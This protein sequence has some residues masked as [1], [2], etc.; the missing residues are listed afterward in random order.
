MNQVQKVENEDE[1]LLF[2]VNS[3]LQDKYLSKHL[4][5]DLGSLGQF[6]KVNE[7]YEPKRVSKVK[8]QTKQQKSAEELAEDQKRLQTI[9]QNPIK[10]LANDV[11]ETNKKDAAN[12]MV[13]ELIGKA[14]G[15]NNIGNLKQTM[16]NELNFDMTQT[17]RLNIIAKSNFYF[18]VFRSYSLVDPQYKQEIEQ[19]LL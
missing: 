10:V 13:G 12:F 19:F 6:M 7:L 1:K 5:A 11:D 17:E 3:T 14:F 15:E 4:K 8:H 16:L 9:K 2:T 18:K